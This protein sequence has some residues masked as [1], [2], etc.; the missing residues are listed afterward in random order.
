MVDDRHFKPKENSKTRKSYMNTQTKI[1][2]WRKDLIV[3][4]VQVD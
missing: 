4:E 2:C 3:K 1:D